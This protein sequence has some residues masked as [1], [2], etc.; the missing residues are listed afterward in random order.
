MLYVII[1]ISIIINIGCY[2]HFTK[3]IKFITAASEHEKE[4]LIT[5]YE[6]MLIAQDIDHRLDPSARISENTENL[7]ISRLVA[8][9]QSNNVTIR[10]LTLPVLAKQLNTNPK[11]LS[12]IIN[13]HKGKN[14][15]H[16]INELRINYILRKFIEEPEYL[17][18]NAAQLADE[19]GFTSRTSFVTTFKNITGTSPSLFKKE[20]KENFK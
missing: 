6:D 3:K 4:N 11:Y 17:D 7:I 10:S 5:K 15:N 12:Y 20:F 16:Y 2:F 1:S 19:A 9:E 13:K 18:R 8:F 14:F